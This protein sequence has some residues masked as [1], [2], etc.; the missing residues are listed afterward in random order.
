M[1]L[2]LL[3]ALATGVGSWL[4]GYPF[5][6]SR[7]EYASL[8][9]IGKVPLASAILFDLGVFSLVLGATVLMLIALAHQSVRRAAR[10][11]ARAARPER[12]AAQ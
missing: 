5:L 7:S 3:V 2:G 9:I 12:E 11:H 8:P 6:T 1:S 10:A 4:F